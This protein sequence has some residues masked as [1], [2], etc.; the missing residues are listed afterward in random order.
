MA[1]S[2]AISSPEVSVFTSPAPMRRGWS[3]DNAVSL[4]AHHDTNN[5]ASEWFFE[6]AYLF[7]EVSTSGGM[8][9]ERMLKCA[10]SPQPRAP[11]PATCLEVLHDVK[12]Q[13]L[14]RK[15]ERIRVSMLKRHAAENA[16]AAVQEIA[17]RALGAKRVAQ[18]ARISGRPVSSTRFSVRNNLSRAS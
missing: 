9:I 14:V 16:R 13:L 7:D 17:K 12:K 5:P 4:V 3:F 11:S 2:A 10:L 1:S 15:S 18:R 8:L 6:S